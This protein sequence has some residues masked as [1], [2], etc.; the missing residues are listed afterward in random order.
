MKKISTAEF[1]EKAKAVHGEKYDYSAIVYKTAKKDKVTI[2]CPEHG[3]FLQVPNSHLNG[4]GCPACGVEQR[5]GVLSHTAET[6]M[7]HAREVHGD[8][9]D[10]SQVQ[11]TNSRTPVTI[12]CRKHGAFQQRPVRH[13]EGSG[14]QKCATERQATSQRGTTAEFISKAR[15]V[16][17]DKYAYSKVVYE[18]S[19]VKVEI[20]CPEH[21]SFLQVPNSHLRGNGCPKCKGAA[22]S[23]AKRIDAKTF[24]ARVQAVHGD[25]YD[26]SNTVYLGSSKNLTVTCKVHGGFSQLAWGHMAGN[27]CPKCKGAAISSAQTRSTEEVVAAARAI[28]GDRYD[29]SLVKY[30]KGTEKVDIMCR[31]HGVFPQTMDNHISGHGCPKCASNASRPE[32][33]ILAIVEAAGHKAEHRYRPIWL[34]GKELDIYVPALKLAIEYCGSHVHNV[35]RN[36]FGAAPKHKQ[37]HYAKWKACHDNGVT[38]ITIYDFLWMTNR[39]K[40]VRMLN[41]KLQKADRRVYARKCEIVELDRATCWDFVKANHI[42]GTGVW[43]YSCTYKGLMHKGELVAVM[44]EQDNDIKRSCTKQ[45]VAVIGGVSRLFK[46]FP[47]MTTMMTT[48]DTGS[49][50]D[51]GIRITKFTL[52]YWW[53]NLRTHEAFTRRAC[54]KHQLESKFGIP[55]GDMTEVQYMTARGFVRV[56]DSGLS[57]FVN[58]Q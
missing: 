53:V 11:Y 56:F 24:I 30:V 29:Y 7:E 15:A 9:Y 42:E 8:T 23:A 57:Y 2:I 5:V 31:K 34:D 25:R 22:A 28:H 46:S 52:R 17:G 48:N 39:D 38:L 27:G 3:A 1:I 13:T 40:I 20:V 45:G 49:S 6:F 37:Y 50:G 58:H 10:Y 26:Y 41:H 12:I 19:Q 4:C 36:V 16:H 47:A 18:G 35:D 33:D 32:L 51:Y 43:K 44:V 21:G 54:Q 55:V 14:C